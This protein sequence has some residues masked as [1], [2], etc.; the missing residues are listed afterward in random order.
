MLNALCMQAVLVVAEIVCL[1]DGC[2]AYL[3]V[4]LGLSRPGLLSRPSLLAR[5]LEHI[6]EQGVCQDQPESCSDGDDFFHA[7]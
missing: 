7:R 3:D 6:Q 1:E 4:R 2:I 5:L